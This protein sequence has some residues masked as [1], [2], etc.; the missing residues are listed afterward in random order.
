MCTSLCLLGLGSSFFFFKLA[1][2]DLVVYV[3]ACDTQVCFLFPSFD[4]RVNSASQLK[5]TH[6]RTHTQGYNSIPK[7]VCHRFDI[8]APKIKKINKNKWLYVPQR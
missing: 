7:P 3:C 5:H 1:H 8:V 4:L 6:T 2:I